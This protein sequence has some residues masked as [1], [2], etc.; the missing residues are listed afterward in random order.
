MSLD[1]AVNL[2][3]IVRLLDCRGVVLDDRTRPI[4]SSVLLRNR[5]HLKYLVNA[6]VSGVVIVAA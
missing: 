5:P 3:P 6:E 2:N 1:Q 4:T